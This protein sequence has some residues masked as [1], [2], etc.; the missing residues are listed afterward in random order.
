MS[1]VSEANHAGRRTTRKGAMSTKLN[2]APRK[3]GGEIGAPLRDIL[4]EHL[5]QRDALDSGDLGFLRG[6]RAM[7]SADV[8]REVNE[9]I[10][11]IHD[12]GELTVWISS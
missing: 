10:E 5:G 1:D 4:L 6:V 8:K 2:W 3:V 9:L 7:A 11:A 12:H